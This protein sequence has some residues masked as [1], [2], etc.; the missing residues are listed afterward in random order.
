MKKI[1]L[2]IAVIILIISGICGC[3]SLTNIARSGN[4]EL[5]YQTALKLYKAEKW[6]RATTMFSA[7]SGYYTGSA[8]EDTIAFF[9]AR[10]LFK[11]R[12]YM[13]AQENLDA[14]RRK[15][16][17]SV[18]IEDAEGMYALCAYYLSPDATRDQTRTAQAIVAI[19]DFLDRYPESTRAESFKKMVNELTI[20]LHEKTFQNAY[21]YFKIEKYKSAVVAFKNALK[22]YG[23]TSHREEIMYY[24]VVS[25]YRLAHSSITT[26]QADRYLSMLDSYYTFKSAYPESKYNKELDRYAKEAKDF[27]DKNKT[28]DNNTI[29]Q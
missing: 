1:I 9:M 24:I 3:G 11:R 27:I 5:M 13:D 28:D 15:F 14:F 2:N 7:C 17:R 8:R 29:A 6:R 18:F 12:E 26:K 23:N 20:R 10:S 16:G 19:T 4:P 22:E 25:S 21:T